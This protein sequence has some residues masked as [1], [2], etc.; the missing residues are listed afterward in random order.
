MAYRL[1]CLASVALLAAADAPPKAPPTDRNAPEATRCRTL[2][3]TGSLVRKERICK[4]NAQWKAIAEQQGGDADNLIE[5]SRAGMDCRA[6]GS[7]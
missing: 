6:S 5:R 2:D 4:T 1:L 3:V 7:C